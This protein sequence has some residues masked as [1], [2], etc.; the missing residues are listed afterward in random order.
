MFTLLQLKCK[1][2]FSKEIQGVKHDPCHVVTPGQ[3]SVAGAFC[4]HYVC[5]EC[6]S[7]IGTDIL[8]LVWGH[9]FQCQKILLKAVFSP[10]FFSLFI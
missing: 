3:Y 7:V 5:V 1:G 8:F 4:V 6:V 9:S 10:Y 2:A